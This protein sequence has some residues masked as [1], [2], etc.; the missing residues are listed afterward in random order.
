[1]TLRALSLALLLAAGLPTAQATTY[2]IDPNHSQV[3]FGYSH[4]GF[5]NIVGVIGGIEGELVYDPG[6][7]AAAAVSVRIPLSALLTGTEK[8][9]THLKSDD[10]FDVAA[11]PI[12]T[13]TSTAVETVAEGRL[14]V[15]GDLVLSGQTRPV[16]LEVT[17]NGLG[18]HPM[19]K[20]PAIGF[21]GRTTLRRSDFGVDKHAPAISDE[22]RVEVTVEAQQ[23]DE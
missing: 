14:R 9:D 8:L 19:S 22:V 16:T 5:S 20:R 1:M 10:F 12:A 18:P 23:R 13:F 4:F 21:D 17:L 11:H 7:P 6:T 3:R 2:R 15:T